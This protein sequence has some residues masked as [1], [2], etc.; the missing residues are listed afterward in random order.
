MIFITNPINTGFFLK[1][2]TFHSRF[3]RFKVVNE[4]WSFIERM[5]CSILKNKKT[6]WWWALF[7]YFNG[8]SLKWL[9]AGFLK[10]YIS[11]VYRNTYENEV[12][13]I[14]VG[15]VRR[16]TPTPTFLRMLWASAHIYVNITTV[17]YTQSSKFKWSR[18][19]IDTAAMSTPWKLFTDTPHMYKCVGT[20]HCAY[21]IKTQWKEFAD[22]KRFAYK[23]TCRHCFTFFASKRT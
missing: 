11:Y 20:L 12:K 7:Q 16:H 18:N 13:P 17:T 14:K 6:L 10:F 9:K 2:K 4:P 1:T 23:S 15:R 19:Y 3:G 21:A 8:K 22:K 5:N